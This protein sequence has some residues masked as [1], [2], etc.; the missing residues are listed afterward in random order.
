M[1]LLYGLAFYVLC[2]LVTG[3]AFVTFGIAQVLPHTGVTMPARILW[4]PGATIFWP[5]VL[6]RWLKARGTA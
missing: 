2:G 6:M 3:V 4:L 5:Y 1:V